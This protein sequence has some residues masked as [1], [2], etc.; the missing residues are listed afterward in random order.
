MYHLKLAVIDTLPHPEI[1]LVLVAVSDP[2]LDAGAIAL[3]SNVSV[4]I[5]P[6]GFCY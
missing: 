3:I 6:S 5:V 1:V 4:I 2:F